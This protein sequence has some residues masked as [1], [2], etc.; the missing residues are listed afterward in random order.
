MPGTWVS[1]IGDTALGGTVHRNLKRLA[2]F[3]HPSIGKSAKATDQDGYGDA[4]DG[5]QVHCRAARNGIG[6]GFE[7]DL[8]GESPDGCRAWRDERPSEPGDRG[9][10][11]EHNHW[12]PTGLGQVAPPHLTAS[13]Q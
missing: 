11:G 9:V 6:I 13:R 2:D 8:A 7:N 4:F 10:T 1:A 5:V 3:T 12:A